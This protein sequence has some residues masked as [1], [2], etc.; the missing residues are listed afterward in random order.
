MISCN[1]EIIKNTTE[2][3]LIKDV[4]PYD[5]YMSVTND[6]EN[7]IEHLYNSDVLCDKQSLLYI[8]SSNR[9]DEIVHLSGNFIC[10]A[11][12]EG[13]YQNFIDL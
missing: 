13:N 10:F 1:F 8:D 2:Y 4:G 9:V 7:L 12:V 6:V 11:P 3:L 5:Q